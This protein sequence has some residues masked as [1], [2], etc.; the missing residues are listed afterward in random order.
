MILAPVLPLLLATKR[1]SLLVRE[2]TLVRRF[3]ISASIIINRC[4][5]HPMNAICSR[6][7]LMVKSAIMHIIAMYLVMDAKLPLMGKESFVLKASFPIQ[8]TDRAMVMHQLSWSKAQYFHGA[9][10]EKDKAKV[11]SDRKEG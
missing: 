10:E 4:T 1:P 8:D 9:M 3:R 6:S 5:I 7:Q 11:L 2:R